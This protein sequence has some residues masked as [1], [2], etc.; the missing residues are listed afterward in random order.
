VQSLFFCK[1]TFPNRQA[2]AGGFPSGHMVSC[3]TD[4]FHK[5]SATPSSGVSVIGHKPI[6]TDSALL[7]FCG[8]ILIHQ[9]LIRSSPMPSSPTGFH[10]RF[11][12]ALAGIGLFAVLGAADPG[13]AQGLIGSTADYELEA[14]EFSLP[15]GEPGSFT[16]QGPGS[17]EFDIEPFPEFEASWSADFGSNSV[18]LTQSTDSDQALATTWNFTN[19][20]PANI[21][22]VTPIDGTDPGTLIS[23][24]NNSILF[25][26]PAFFTSQSPTATFSYAIATGVAPSPGAGVPAPLPVFAAA[27]CFGWSRKLRSRCRVARSAASPIL[28]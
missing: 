23:F 19:F 2:F 14:T 4:D 7:L 9:S 3:E 10:S 21:I 11:F 18:V 12:P 16:V 20:S 17:P 27:G 28:S 26:T 5:R 6:S 22:S 24:T 15:I 1:I 13:R 25:S 8:M